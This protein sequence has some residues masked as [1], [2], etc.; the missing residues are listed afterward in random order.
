MP[1][2]PPSAPRRAV[3]FAETLRELAT[4]PR[5]SAATASA[6]I[7]P[8]ARAARSF[9]CTF[10]LREARDEQLAQ[11]RRRADEEG[12]HPPFIGERGPRLSPSLCGCRRGCAGLLEDESGAVRVDADRVALTEVA[13]EQPQ[14]ERVLDEPLDRPLQRPRAVR[15]IPARLRD[16]LLRRVGQLDLQAPVGEPV[17]QPRELHL[18]DLA[19]LL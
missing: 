9:F 6:A 1:A 8:R 7:A 2:N 14:R 12:P 13:L 4:P 11:E 18:D 5:A 16:E 19:Q 15:G 10:R 3:S 17:A